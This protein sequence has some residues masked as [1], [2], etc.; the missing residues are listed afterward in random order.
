MLRVK[1]FANGFAIEQSNTSG[2]EQKQG[3]W[4][5]KQSNACAQNDCSGGNGW[6]MG[7]G[8]T[9]FAWAAKSCKFLPGS[10]CPVTNC[11]SRKVSWTFVPAGRTKSKVSSGMLS[12]HL[13]RAT[14]TTNKS[15]AID[16]AECWPIRI[17]IKIISDD[18][19]GHPQSAPKRFPFHYLKLSHGEALTLYFLELF[20]DSGHKPMLLIENDTKSERRIGTPP[21]TAPIL[22]TRTKNPTC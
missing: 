22:I 21:G 12:F 8:D 2:K 17:R 7:N 10:A 9:S 18:F 1:P 16:L 20:D 14:S 13:D 11:T 4:R 19:D 6:K 15:L 5:S 3:A